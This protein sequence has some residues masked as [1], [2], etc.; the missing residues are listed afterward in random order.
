MVSGLL[1]LQVEQIYNIYPLGG[2]FY[3]ALQID[4]INKIASASVGQRLY[5]YLEQELNF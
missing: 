2:G 5:C 3:L 4:R 1:S